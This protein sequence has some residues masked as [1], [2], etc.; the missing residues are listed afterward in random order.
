MSAMGQNEDPQGSVSGLPAEPPSLVRFWREV[1]KIS[2][3]DINLT[4]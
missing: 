1:L 3:G 4:K 2:V